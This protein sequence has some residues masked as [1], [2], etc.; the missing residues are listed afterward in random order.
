M[1]CHLS[2]LLMA[3]QG[4]HA[5]WKN[6]FRNGMLDLQVSRQTK[7]TELHVLTEVFGMLDRSGTCLA[8]TSHVTYRLCVTNAE[9]VS[10]AECS[11]IG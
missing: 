8:L 6:P 4:D 1:K 10:I 5:C 2:A 7:R 11:N 3:L 9:Q